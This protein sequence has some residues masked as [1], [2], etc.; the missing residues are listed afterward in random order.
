MKVEA[1]Y[2]DDVDIKHEQDV[3]YNLLASV[4]S[5]KEVKDSVLLCVFIYY[6]RL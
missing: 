1:D 2:C 6:L 3:T 4:K 5:L